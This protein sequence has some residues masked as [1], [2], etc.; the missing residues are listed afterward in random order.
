MK[1]KTNKKF[2][3]FRY[4]EGYVNTVLKLLPYLTFFYFG[5]SLLLLPFIISVQEAREAVGIVS[6]ILSIP[7]AIFGIICGV[8][9]RKRKKWAVISLIAIVSLNLLGKILIISSSGEG[10]PPV[11]EMA[12]LAFLIIGLV[13]IIKQG[14]NET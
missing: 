5:L 7:I 13:G 3:L 10:S 11:L 14:K 2:K 9:L 6:V 12:Y 8:Y 4:N 1:T